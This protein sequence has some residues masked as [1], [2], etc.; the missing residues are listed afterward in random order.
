MPTVSP[1]LYG[2]HWKGDKMPKRFVLSVDQSTQGTKSLIFDATGRM[3]CRRDLPHKQLID[4]NC[5]VSHDPIEIYKNLLQGVRDVVTQ[6]GVDPQEIACLGI[7]NQRETS[8]AW[9]RHTG[10]PVCGAIVWHCARAQKI[11][12]RISAQGYGAM[13]QRRTGLPISPYFPASK[14]AWILE[15]IPGARERA[16]KH[17]LCFGTVDTWLIYKLTGGREYKTDYSNAARTQLFDLNL[18]QWDDEI[19]HLFGLTATDLAQVCDSDEFFCNTDLEGYFPTPIPICAVL[20]DSNAALFG[21]G[22]LERGMV[23]ATYGTGSSIMLNLGEKLSSSSYRLVTSLAWKYRGII[24]YV[25]EGNVNYT[26]AVISW[27]QNDVCLITSADETQT[28]A[29]M[30]NSDDTTYFI[31]AFTGLGAPYWNSHVKGIICGIT[32]RTGKAELVRAG[33]NCIAYQITDIVKAMEQ[34]VD[35]PLKEL[36]VD[37]GPTRNRY[38]MQFQSDLLNKSVLVPD[39]EELSGIGA[40]YM[41]GLSCGLFDESIFHVLRRTAYTSQMSSEKREKHYQ[42]WRDAV[43]MLL[44]EES[45]DGRNL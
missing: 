30:A 18:L 45:L 35:F 23:K 28:L 6:A 44:G 19:C 10:E 9:D 1:P 40:A 25:M 5:G 7:S 15:N 2:G 34:D 21:Q 12:E 42:G 20:G 4:K 8:L 38:L 27:L 41:A 3:I 37:G 22:C 14:L 26:G 13:I 11:S 33:L 16:D 32:R 17:E 24:Q 29:E 43:R 39:M 36:R 31:P